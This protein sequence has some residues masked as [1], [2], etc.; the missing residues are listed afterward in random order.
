MP[1]VASTVLAYAAGLLAGIGNAL[2]WSA[3]AM[4]AVLF[5]AGRA[6]DR[7]ALV[8]I[9]VGG[10]AAGHV[11]AETER[12]CAARALMAPRWTVV[13]E[14]DASP[15][16]FVRA[17]H[18]CGAVTRLVVVDG[19]APAGAR[20]VASGEA[21][22]GRA[23]LLMT[24]ATLHQVAGPSLAP[25]WRS[26][27]GRGI[28]RA[29]GPRAPMVR[30]LLIADMRELSPN[31][32]ERFAASGLSHML[33][34]SGLHVG[35]IAAAVLLLA[36]VAGV[37]RVRAELFAAVLT[38]AYVL[39]IGAPLPAVRAALMLGAVSLSRTVQ[40]PTS[41]WAVLAVGAGLP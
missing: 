24:D 12:R 9:G 20:V 26:E 34:V 30:A 22:R 11:T 16:A 6:R 18:D 37:G 23:G 3:C 8:A 33:S 7:L 25:R 10:L 27:I 5:L 41:A 1:L 4:A 17:R 28:D 35:L 29:F 15:G 32:R 36:Q 38:A 40:R 21:S 31:V 2:T 13:L 19:A 14:A 39:L